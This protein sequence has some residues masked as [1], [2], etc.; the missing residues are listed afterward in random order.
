MKLC[1][2]GLATYASAAALLAVHSAI[3]YS[4]ALLVEMT[5]TRPRGEDHQEAVAALRRACAKA[6]IEHRGIAHLQKLLGVKT[7]VS[8]GDRHVDDSKIEA[9]C[10]TAERFRVWA[11]RILQDRQGRKSS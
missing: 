7:D 11:E 6:R 9:L 1:Q 10:I 2:D 4:D 8:Y 5:G 3:S